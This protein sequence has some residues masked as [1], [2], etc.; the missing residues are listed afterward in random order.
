MQRQADHH[1]TV[2]VNRTVQLA[3]DVSYLFRSFIPF[4]LLIGI[5]FNKC[6]TSLPV[7]GILDETLCVVDETTA[8]GGD[9]M[10]KGLVPFCPWH[11]VYRKW[12][13]S[14]RL[15]TYVFRMR[16]QGYVGH[17]YWRRLLNLVLSAMSHS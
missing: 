4:I 8:S 5:I 12:Q 14:R 6:D 11:L 16:I 17:A 13:C 9:Q 7:L 2:S 1:Q 15:A 3:S 10:E